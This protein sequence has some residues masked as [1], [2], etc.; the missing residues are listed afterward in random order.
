ML[1]GS[2][3]VNRDG[4]LNDDKY[5]YEEDGYPFFREIGEIIYM[6]ELQ[7]KRRHT[8]DLQQFRINYR[9]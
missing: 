4:I 8:P 1:T 6:Y 5:E 9:E 3:Y 7:R 2:I